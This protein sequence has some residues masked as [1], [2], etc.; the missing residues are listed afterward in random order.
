VDSLRIGFLIDR[1]EPERGGAERALAALAGHLE[2]RG[3][4]ILVFG[5]RESATPEKAPGTFHRVKAWGLTRPAREL[6][7]GRHLVAAAAAA[8]CGLTLGIR[9]LPRVDFYWPHGGSHLA[10]WQALRRARGRAE[11]GSPRGRHRTFIALEEKLLARGGARRIVCV[12]EL[13]RRE[14]VRFYPACRNRLR[15]IPNGIDLDRFHPRAR[16]G[17]GQELRRRIGLEEEMPLLLFP[18]ANP[19]L[20][21]LDPLTRVLARLTGRPWHLLAAGAPRSRCTPY[22]R[23][24]PRERV[25]WLRRADGAALAAAADLLVL[26]AWREPFGLAIA[27]ALACGTP[28]ITTTRAG[29]ADLIEGEQAG[30]VLAHP[31]DLAGLAAA[32]ED[33]LGRPRPS[34][35]ERLQV[36]RNVIG[37]DRARWL[38]RLEEELLSLA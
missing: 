19:R 28:V 7:L 3:H 20:K 12:S 31:A 17:V 6:S 26:P 9:H 36:R 22:L 27:E 30:R 21:G 25:T 29:A 2:S 35:E 33:F 5:A 14:L 16:E 8:G 23:R 18:A 4:R 24:L 38:R 15:V 32:L 10:T 13:V 1:W 34:G 11:E 37:L